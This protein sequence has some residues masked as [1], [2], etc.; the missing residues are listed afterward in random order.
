MLQRAIISFAV[1]IAVLFVASRFI[2]GFSVTPTTASFLVA[3]ALLTLANA[4]VK[5][6][7][8]LF[9]FPLIILT[10]GLFTLVINA[11][12]LYALDVVLTSVTIAGLVPLAYATL[13]ATVGNLLR[14]TLK[15][16]RF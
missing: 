5:P 16:K 9:F 8:K 4:L 11:V 14:S 15:K 10:L 6:I 2:E 7:L 13:I 12:L 3:A 1:N